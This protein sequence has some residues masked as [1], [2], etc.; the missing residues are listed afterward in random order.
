M[1]VAG[2][3]GP[4]NGNPLGATSGIL[5]MF[6]SGRTRVSGPAGSGGSV[7]RR[8]SAFDS[9]EQLD[10][11]PGGVHGQRLPTTATFDDRGPEGDPAGT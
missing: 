9:L 6:W 10:H 7:A 8:R 11:V 2:F 4:L 5:P 1:H 3:W